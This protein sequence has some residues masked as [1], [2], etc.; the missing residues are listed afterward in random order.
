MKGKIDQKE[1]MIINL[2]APNVSAPNFNKHNLKDLKAYINSNTVVVGDFNTTLSSID[3]SSKQK[4]NKEILDLKHTIDQMDLVDVYRIFNPNS[5]QY[6]FFLA[7]HR[8]FSKIDHILRHK[9][10]CNEYKKIEVIPCILSDH[11]ALKLELKNKNKDQKHANN[12]KLNNSLFNE[13]WVIDEIKE[14]KRFLE[15]N[16]NENTTNQ[17]LWDTAKAVVR[18]KLIAM[19]AYIKKTEISQINDRMIQF[20]LLEKQEQVNPKT[21]T[22]GEIIKLRAEVNEIETKKK[23]TKN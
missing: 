22:R 17:N 4:I 20:K 8:T 23:H 13:Q 11:N 12:W 7:A 16:E 15:V 14:D 21:N 1:I 5:T 18:G 6:T 19:S 9:T 3:K 10:S 2:Y